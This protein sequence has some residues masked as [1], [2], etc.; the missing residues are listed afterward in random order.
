MSQPHSPDTGHA[1]EHAPPR[2]PSPRQPPPGRQLPPGPRSR[3]GAVAWA[4]LVL[5]AAVG[6]VA[7]ALG[8]GSAEDAPAESPPVSVTDCQVTAGSYGLLT[9]TAS[10]RITNDTGEPHSYLVTVS[11]DDAAGTSLGEIHATVDGLPDGSAVTE[12]ATGVVGDDTP[13]GAAACHVAAV[14]PTS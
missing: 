3:F 13:P 8:L 4:V 2:I 1:P 11:I 7:G 5:G 9:A 6:Q 14:D 12:R 10:V